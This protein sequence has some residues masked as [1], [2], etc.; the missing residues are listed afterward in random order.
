MALG[1]VV[2]VVLELEIDQEVVEV[3]GAYCAFLEVDQEV[4]EVEVEVEGAL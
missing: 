1:V 2:V 3:E 4:G